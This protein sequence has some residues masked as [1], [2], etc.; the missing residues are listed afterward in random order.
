M[1]EVV[2]EKKLCDGCRADVRDG[3]V[4]CYNCGTSLSAEKK[5]FYDGSPKAIEESANEESAV[6]PENSNGIANQP[7]NRKKEVRPA[8]IRRQRVK[9]D[10]P[11]PVEYTWTPPESAGWGFVAATI[12][13]TGLTLLFLALAL[14]LR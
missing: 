12:V 8:V 4:F 3:S 1:A 5:V 13:F 2:L 11:K 14:Y 6:V 10:R 9:T 7:A